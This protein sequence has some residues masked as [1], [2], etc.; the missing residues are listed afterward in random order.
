MLWNMLNLHIIQV[1]CPNQHR[2]EK[3]S[4]TIKY[5]G[6]VISKSIFVFKFNGNSFSKDK[7]IQVRSLVYLNNAKKG[8]FVPNS[9]NT[10]LLGLGLDCI[11]YLLSNT[12]REQNSINRVAKKKIDLQ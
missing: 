1:C 12:T 11:V 6:K 7:L 10:C 8:M 3:I 4:S 5:D 9:K 2:N